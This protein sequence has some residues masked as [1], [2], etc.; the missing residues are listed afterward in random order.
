MT[1]RTVAAFLTPEG[2]SQ[3]SVAAVLREGSLVTEAG[4]YAVQA[5]GARGARRRTPYASRPVRVTEPVLLVPGFLAGDS[6]LAPMSRTLRHQGFRTYRAD[7]RANVGCT[8]AAARQLE[9]RLEE[10]SQRR[11]SRVRVVGHSLG[12]MLARGVAAR[13][14]DLV[15]GIVTMGSPVLAPGA[16]HAS[17]ARSVDLLVRLNRAGMR[18]LMAE[19]CVAGTCAQESFDQARAPWPQGLDFTAVFSRRDGIVDWRACVDPA[20]HPVEVRSS[21]VGMAFDPAVITAVSLALRPVAVASVVE[22]DRGEIA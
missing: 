11:G 19:D 7:I 22:V 10:I 6:S 21:H 18:G 16:H 9:E 20:A 14:P 13:R 2:F 8:L 17:L 4:R 5:F 15:A 3:P 12:G 1:Q